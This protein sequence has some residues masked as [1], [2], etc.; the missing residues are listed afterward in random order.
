MSITGAARLAGIMGWPVAH[1][2]SPALHGY[3]LAEY[4][5]DGAYVPLAVKPER[6]EQALR[7]LPALGFR[8][9]NL[10]IPHKQTALVAM[11]RVDPVAQRIG[12]INTVVVD[13]KGDLEGSNTDAFGFRENL[14]EQAPQWTSS[15]GPAVVLGAGGS[16]RA[17]VAALG[18]AGVEQIRLVN[19]SPG[20]AERLASDLAVPSVRITVH[21]WPQRAEALDVAAL[22]V[23]T[24]SLGMVGEPPLEIDLA[25]FPLTGVVVDIVYVPLET[26]LLAAARRRGH[27]AV[28]GL[29]ML[30]HQGRP[31]FAAWFGVAP[32][33][34]SGLRAAMLATFR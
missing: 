16:A 10:T 29:G 30:L 25:A 1:S 8:G 17:V 33:V 14:R 4:R 9:C 32:R 19:R 12:A 18:E 5:A 23:N 15:A 6:L 20:R 21:R 34:T 3:W 7:A 27:T 22:L 2:R 28:D 11:D 24:T 26:G 13:A 31:G